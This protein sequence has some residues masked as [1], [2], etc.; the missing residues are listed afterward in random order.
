MSRPR[1]A[2]PPRRRGLFIFWGAVLA[3]LA[4]TGSLT[5]VLLSH[6]AT[7]TSLLGRG[8]SA[9]D[10]PASRA[11]HAVPGAGVLHRSFS[12]EGSVGVLFPGKTSALVLVVTNPGKMAIKVTSIMTTVG[13]GSDHCGEANVTVT[14]FAGQLL[15]PAGK[16]RHATVYV[17][18]VHSAPDACQVARFPFA[19]S[20]RAIAG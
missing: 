17:T 19:Y 20:G 12:I 10:M 16:A 8:K 5:A 15:V 9:G 11:A 13:G 7:G 2:D 6:G 18:L 3:A 14:P 4:L 1:P